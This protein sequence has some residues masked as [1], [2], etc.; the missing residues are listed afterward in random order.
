MAKYIRAG[1]SARVSLARPDDV[2]LRFEL[3]MSAGE[4]RLLREEIASAIQQSNVSEGNAL[5]T[6]GKMVGEML[7][8]CVERLEVTHATTGWATMSE[9]PAQ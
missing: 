4:W 7:G 8:A 6:L 3:T 2:P 5:G 1:T 9:D